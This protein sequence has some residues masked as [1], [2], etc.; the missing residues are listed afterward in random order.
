MKNLIKILRFINN[1]DCVKAEIHGVFCNGALMCSD[2]L[3]AVA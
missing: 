2:T 3:N 1:E